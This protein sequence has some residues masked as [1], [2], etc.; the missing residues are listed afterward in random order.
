MGKKIGT[1]E[2]GNTLC[3]ISTLCVINSSILNCE[4]HIL[5]LLSLRYLDGS[6]KESKLK[7]MKIEIHTTAKVYHRL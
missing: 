4:S 2:C 5:K 7:D 3:L 1:P 6:F